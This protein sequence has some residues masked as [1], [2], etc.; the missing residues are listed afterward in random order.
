MTLAEI[1]KN[2]AIFTDENFSVENILS[3]A[4]RA[5]SRINVECK[6]LFPFYESTTAEYTAIPAM[7]QFDMISPYL[8]YG[9]KMNDSSLSEANIYLDEFYKALNTFK[10]S[11]GSLVEAYEKGDTENGISGEYINSIGYGGVYG[12]DTSDAINIGF[13]GYNGN[14]GFY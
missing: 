12:I 2:S 11:I 1:T 4:N 6:T 8:S 5:I 10:D 14:G 7:H 13:F 3:L 9:I